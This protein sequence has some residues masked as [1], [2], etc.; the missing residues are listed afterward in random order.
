MKFI[1]H[2]KGLFHKFHE[3]TTCIM[4]P[5]KPSIPVLRHRQTVETQIRWSGSALFANRNFCQKYKQYTRH[6]KLEVID[7]LLKKIPSIFPAFGPLQI[8]AFWTCQQ[9]NLENCLSYGLEAWSADRG[10]WVDYFWTNSVNFFQTMALCKFGHLELLSK[11]SQKWI[12]LGS[13]N[14]VSW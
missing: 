14:F 1:R 5:Y 3:K 4:N 6:S 9:D 13:W 2:P 11:I 7:F 8:G 12:K 10:W